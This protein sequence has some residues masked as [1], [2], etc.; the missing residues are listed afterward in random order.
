M[1]SKPFTVITAILLLVLAVFHL[2]R[3][4]MDFQIVVGGHP[5]PMWGSIAHV[6]IFG[7]LSW[8]LVREAR[9]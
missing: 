2:L 5:V 9:R 8:G 1:G 7:L 3:L 4:V 6:V